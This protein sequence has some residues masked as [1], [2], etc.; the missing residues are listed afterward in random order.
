MISNVLQTVLMISINL[1]NDY[2]NILIHEP[3]MF[4]T[5]SSQLSRGLLCSI[6]LSL[7]RF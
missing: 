2:F 5:T 1:I 6:S 4:W 3:F 7:S